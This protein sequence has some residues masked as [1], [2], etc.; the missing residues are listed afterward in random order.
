MAKKPHLQLRRGRYY[1]RQ[2]VP[3]DI[4]PIIKR[5]EFV[6]SLKTDQLEIAQ[7]MAREYQNQAFEACM[8]IRVSL[9]R[10]GKPD[11][12][13]MNRIAPDLFPQNKPIQHTLVEVIDSWL[14]EKIP[15]WSV[16]T[17]MQH[18]AAVRL[19][20]QFINR[21]AIEKINR[22]DC[23]AF[24]DLIMKL[25]ANYS[26]KH[27]NVSLHEIVELNAPPMSVS[28]INR[29][30]GI[31]CSLFNYM[32]QQSIIE[33]NPFKNLSVK[34]H[35]RIDAERAA[36]SDADIAIIFDS[37]RDFTGAKYWLPRIAAY[38]G[39]R[40]EEI[41]QLTAKDIQQ[42]DNVWCFIVGANGRVKTASSIRNV[43]IHHWLLSNG[44]LE[45][46][47]KQAESLWP[48]LKP[49]A[50]GF[51]SSIYSKWFGR[52]LKQVGLKVPGKSFHS[53]RHSF[54][55]KLKLANAPE[56]MVRQVVGHTNDSITFGR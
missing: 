13:Y 36:Y 20:Q 42:I 7:T 3:A 5:V 52:H 54:I 46:A 37:I 11:L 17:R 19:F 28:N 44:F 41:A 47:Q 56:A 12:E 4:R 8:Y 22:T 6:L 55:T 24:R 27:R 30:L 45:Y 15:N 43:P 49:A 16:K 40:M 51:R 9:R 1:W 50:D 26:K 18:E 29:I 2:R 48:E 31:N 25:P 14:T 39:M 10:S 34:S 21:K 33:I 32:V 38:S 23:V 35:K 53:F